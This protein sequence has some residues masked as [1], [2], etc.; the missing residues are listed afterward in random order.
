MNCALRMNCSNERELPQRGHELQNVVL[1]CGKIFNADVSAIYES[2]RLSIHGGS[3][4]MK[5]NVFQIIL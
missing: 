4:I 2:H 3:Q 5:D 1:H